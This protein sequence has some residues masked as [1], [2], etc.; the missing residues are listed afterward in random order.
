M[1]FSGKFGNW[2]TNERLNFGG[3]ADHRLDTGLVSGFV[4]IGIYGKSLM[5]INLLLI[6]I[7][8][9][10]QLI[11]RAVAEVCSALSQCF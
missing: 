2:P 7:R 10:A 8:Q 3:D 4:T 1:K 5:G 6:L 11:R 9:M